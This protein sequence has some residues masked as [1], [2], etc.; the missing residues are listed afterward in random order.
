[1]GQILGNF[2]LAIYN[3]NQK[4]RKLMGD[5]YKDEP[6]EEIKSKFTDKMKDFWHVDIAIGIFGIRNLRFKSK[7][8][9]ITISLSNMEQTFDEDGKSNFWILKLN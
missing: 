6:H 9:K 7:K 5:K 4:K 3:K 2:H 1:M 8:P